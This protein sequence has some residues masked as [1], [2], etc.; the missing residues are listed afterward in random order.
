MRKRRRNALRCFDPTQ[1]GHGDIDDGNIRL[2]QFSLR[3]R[4]PP[5][6]RLSDHTESRLAFQQKPQA[7]AHYGVIVS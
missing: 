4:L 1:I 5:I 2:G 3:H 7:P 6:R